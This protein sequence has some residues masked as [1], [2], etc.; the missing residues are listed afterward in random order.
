MPTTAESGVLTRK[1]SL[2]DR[3][4]RKLEE[5]TVPSFEH[6][7]DDFF[8]RRAVERI[9]QVLAEAMIDTAERWPA[10]TGA[11]PPA[12]SGEA[13]ARL[14]EAGVISHGET[15]QRIVK[16]RN[17]VVHHYDSLDEAILYDILTR[18]LGDLRRFVTEVWAHV[19]V[20]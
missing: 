17:F 12:T 2:M 4:L 1:L 7:R 14:A 18:R 16:F 9:L 20:E 3:Y 8:L 6:F 13:V 15:C 5:L 10:L 11:P 19:G